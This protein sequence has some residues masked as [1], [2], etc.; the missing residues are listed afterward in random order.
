MFHGIRTHE[1]ASGNTYTDH[2][3]LS[4]PEIVKLYD[5]LHLCSDEIEECVIH[6][7]QNGLNPVFDTSLFPGIWL[8]PQA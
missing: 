5:R 1:P 6:I 3:R 7:E 4:I 8:F 2:R